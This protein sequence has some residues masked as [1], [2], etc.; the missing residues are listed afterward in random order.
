MENELKLFWRRYFTFNWKFGLFLTLFICILRFFLVLDANKT[1]NYSYIGLIMV[2]SAIVP[3]IFLSKYGRKII[4]LTKP[5]NT[6]WL[7]ISF[8]IGICFSFLLYYIGSTLYANS[9]E[10]WYVYI[11]KS[12]N[13][14]PGISSDDRMV[15]FSI[16]AITGMIFSPIGEELFFRGIVHSSFAKSFG[17][18]NASIIDGLAFALTHLSHFGL[19]FLNNKWL[20]LPIPSIIWVISMFIASILFY[21]CKKKTQSI[22]GAIICHSAFNLGMIFCIFYLI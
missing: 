18:T 16:M 10:N 9:Y 22:L 17:N 21:I 7:A 6:S 13:I 3:F 2:I 14:P 11:G 1:A 12:Y 4:G 8:I 20:F 5:K 19:V 15:L